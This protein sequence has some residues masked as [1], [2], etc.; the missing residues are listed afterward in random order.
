MIAHYAT[1]TEADIKA[2][3]VEDKWLATIQ[4]EVAGEVQRLTQKL[5]DRVQKLEER[6]AQP[7]PVAEE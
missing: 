3:V 1:L 2:L 6:Y 7:L 5:T 4:S